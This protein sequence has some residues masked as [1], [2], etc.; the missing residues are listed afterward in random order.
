MKREMY[1]QPSV[2]VHNVEIWSE[3]PLCAGSKINGEH[4]GYG[5]D[6]PF[7]AKESEFEHDGNYPNPFSVWE[8][9]KLDE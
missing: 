3:K 9:D 1:M 8:K 5:E 2:R 6:D 4:P 7:G